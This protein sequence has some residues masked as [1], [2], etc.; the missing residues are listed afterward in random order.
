MSQKMKQ[1]SKLFHR[2]ISLCTLFIFAFLCS[3]KTVDNKLVNNSSDSYFT[4]KKVKKQKKDVYVIYANR[5]DSLFKIV[6]YYDKKKCGKK[7]K[8]GMRFQ[9]SL[10]SVF[11][12]F[13][14]ETKMIPPCNLFMEFHGIA[15]GKEPERGIDDVWFCEVLNGPYLYESVK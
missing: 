9:A 10:Q 6:S 7:L 1:L 3:C 14:R 5:N 15:I 8:K 12:D 13:E 2:H 11:G 4:V